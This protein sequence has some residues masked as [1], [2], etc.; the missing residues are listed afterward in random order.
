M[1]CVVEIIE[2]VH[3]L[4]NV[5]VLFV[6]RI[7]THKEILRSNRLAIPAASDDRDCPPRL[8]S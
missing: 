5:I 6:E 4:A 7:L 3:F 1:R 2:A 8:P